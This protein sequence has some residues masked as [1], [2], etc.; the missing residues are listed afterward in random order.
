MGKKKLIR[1]IFKLA[2]YALGIIH[3][4]GFELMIFIKNKK[5]SKEVWHWRKNIP[6][7]SCVDKTV[8]IIG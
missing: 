1:G 2:S 5:K 7:N 3:I 8:L 4:W 6:V